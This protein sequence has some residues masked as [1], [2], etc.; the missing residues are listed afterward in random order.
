MLFHF[1]V[2]FVVLVNRKTKRNSAILA[3]MALWMI[4]VRLLDLF[5]ILGPEA[6]PGGLRIHWL[7]VSTVMGLGGVWVALF[8]GHLKGRPLLP[9]KDPELAS[10]LRGP[11][12]H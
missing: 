11:E 7:D 12:G 4:A 9:L 10:A 6:Y 8:V 5:Y 1:A 2:P 3:G